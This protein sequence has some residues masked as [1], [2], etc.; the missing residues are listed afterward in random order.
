LQERPLLIRFSGYLLLLREIIQNTWT[1]HPDYKNLCDALTRMEKI[2]DI[3][4]KSKGK[5]DEKSKLI[6]IEQSLEPRF[7]A[8]C[9]IT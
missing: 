6:E 3:I 2:A 5:A 8:A 9:Q 7:A 4:N 1:S